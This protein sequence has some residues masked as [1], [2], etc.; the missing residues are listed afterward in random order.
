MVVVVG[1]VAGNPPDEVN[2]LAVE[3]VCQLRYQC[4]MYSKTR[5]R[6]FAIQVA[7]GKHSRPEPCAAMSHMHE[8]QG[9]VITY[10]ITN[11]ANV[12]TYFFAKLG[13]NSK[14]AWMP[15]LM[16]P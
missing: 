12:H 16:F 13:M 3:L 9:H 8:L 2:V 7:N 11:T 1:V 10:C 4:G 5:A 15:F 14:N 6:C